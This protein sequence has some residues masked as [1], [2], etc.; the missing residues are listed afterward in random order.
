MSFRVPSV[1][2]DDRSRQY[3]IPSYDPSSYYVRQA[4]PHNHNVPQAVP[5]DYYAPVAPL[6]ENPL[7]ELRR[8]VN[9]DACFA[10]SA[11]SPRLPPRHAGEHDSVGTTLLDRF[12]YQQA[13]QPAAPPTPRT[14]AQ[15]F[16]V[17]FLPVP[18]VGQSTWSYTQTPM[19]PANPRSVWSFLTQGAQAV[20]AQVRLVLT[21]GFSQRL[22]FDQW[23]PPPPPPGPPPGNG[24]HSRVQSIEEIAAPRICSDG[25]NTSSNSAVSTFRQT[26][27]GQAPRP[28]ENRE[29]VSNAPKIASYRP[30]SMPPPVK[31][32]ESHSPV[33][34]NEQ[35]EATTPQQLL[36]A[37]LPSTQYQPA[38]TTLR[39][40]HENR[41]EESSSAKGTS[42]KRNKKPLPIDV[43]KAR[44]ETAAR[45]EGSTAPPQSGGTAG[46][47][48]P[49]ANPISPSRR[50]QLSPINTQ[51]N[52][53]QPPSLCI[54]VVLSPVL[55]PSLSDALSPISFGARSPYPF[56]EA[57]SPMS[58]GEAR[59]PVSFRIAR[60]PSPPVWSPQTPV[61]MSFD[62]P[63]F[64]QH[65]SPPLPALSWH[66]YDGRD[67]VIEED[68]QDETPL[69]LVPPQ[70][71]AFTESITPNRERSS[72]TRPSRSRARS[73]S[74]P[75]SA[76]PDNSAFSWDRASVQSIYATDEDYCCSPQVARDSMME[77]RHYKA[78]NHA[79]N[80]RQAILGSYFGN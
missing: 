65:A 64:I 35:E 23:V 2:V 28:L 30:D 47:I 29:L 80:P 54:D 37:L 14:P 77:D 50:R 15:P 39:F 56:G 66:D 22:T 45:L 43:Q 60:S 3:S 31:L 61:A 9:K 69:E 5:L 72:R 32:P 55:S 20:Q 24:R 18:Q 16:G 62:Y 7:L 13:Y 19:T 57:R 40:Q 44:D 67:S 8:P 53:S 70:G 75:R 73:M 79:F 11:L 42:P 4:N 12:L 38:S 52:N 21:S 25:T 49:R 74:P 33:S 46:S 71:R 41:G 1:V 36:P 6:S 58:F 26:A 76:H 10:V 59:S 51:V 68:I 78:K 27:R 34:T 17:P 63:I 48:T